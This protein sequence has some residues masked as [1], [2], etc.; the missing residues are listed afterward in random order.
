MD[1]HA[2]TTQEILDRISRHCPEAMSSYLHCLNRQ[3]NDG[4]VL[5]TR[6][7]VEEDMSESYTKFKKNIKKLALEALLEWHPD[8]D[9]ISVLL[10]P[11]EGDTDEECV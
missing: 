10:A 7:M 8:G 3:D 9:D 1:I 6:K 4:R 5:F 2:I 11:L